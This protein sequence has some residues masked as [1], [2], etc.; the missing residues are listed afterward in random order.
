M[1]KLMMIFLAFFMISCGYNEHL[2]VS[3][4]ASKEKC[5]YGGTKI[6]SGIDSNHN[7][8]LDK[9]EYDVV[10]YACKEKGDEIYLF[11]LENDSSESTKVSVGVDF[12][13][14]KKLDKDEIFYQGDFYSSKVLNGDYI[15]KT[16]EDLQAI[17]SYS[18]IA[19]DLIIESS[20][21]VL[22]EDDDLIY[23]DASPTLNAVGG[24][25]RVKNSKIKTFSIF[26]HLDYAGAVEFEDNDKLQTIA[27]LN[28]LSIVGNRFVVK[29]NKSL[30]SVN[31]GNYEE[32]TG[33]IGNLEIS[34][35]PKLDIISGFFA[36]SKIK[37]SLTISN[38]SSLLLIK[39]FRFLKDINSINI[40]N[41]DSLEEI[42][43]FDNL[44]YV[45]EDFD[46]YNNK[47]LFDCFVEKIRKRLKKSA[48]NEKTENNKIDENC[49]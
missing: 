13:K 39:G 18:F 15:I 37:K 36:F 7:G 34:S 41:N 19:G 31:I 14:N 17:A 25:I 33:K 46:I 5:P 2:F 16:K 32:G 35:N 26:N 30:H 20:D 10:H 47:N 24:V 3:Q 44:E 12:N 45:F 48:K 21:D 9:D 49:K 42:L 27:G 8:S 38:N 23:D 28:D 22:V 43:G 6:I 29:N 40:S 4:D 1:Y 11:K